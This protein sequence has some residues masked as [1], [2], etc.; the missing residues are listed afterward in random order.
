M[1]ALVDGSMVLVMVGRLVVT[2][3]G[4]VVLGVVICC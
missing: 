2:G 1:A 4:E 3:V